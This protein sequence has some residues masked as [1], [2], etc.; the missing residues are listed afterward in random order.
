MGL[1]LNWSELKKL[2]R[3]EFVVS[4]T[5]SWSDCIKHEIINY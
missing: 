5:G 4:V 3:D 1:P 2:F